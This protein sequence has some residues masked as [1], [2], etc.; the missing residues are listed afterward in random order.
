[1]VVDGLRARD[2]WAKRTARFNLVLASTGWPLRRWANVANQLFFRAPMRF[3]FLANGRGNGSQTEVIDN[4]YYGS[5]PV[6]TATKVPDSI[7]SS[8]RDRITYALHISHRS[9]SPYPLPVL[10]PRSPSPLSVPSPRARTTCPLPVPTPRS[11]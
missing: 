4:P 10:I 9:C 2:C 3:D 1:M 6:G 8:G 5:V 7:L 11:Y